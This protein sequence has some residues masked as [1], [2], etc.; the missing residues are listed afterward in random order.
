MAWLVVLRPITSLYCLMLH[1]DLESKVLIP[2]SFYYKCYYI[3]RTIYY[4]GLFFAF[5]QYNCYTKWILQFLIFWEIWTF[6]FF[7]F[8]CP[9]LIG[10]HKKDNDGNWTRRIYVCSYLLTLESGINIPNTQ[11]KEPILSKLRQ[12]YVKANK[13][14]FP[15]ATIEQ[16]FEI[17][18]KNIIF[19]KIIS[20]SLCAAK[21]FSASN[22][23]QEQD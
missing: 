8:V 7:K 3:F 19:G 10:T 13:V 21:L 15:T 11:M 16:I 1:S 2:K 6:L 20:R 22:C 12:F 9:I 4:E 14:L 18:Y 5:L 17:Y 23:R